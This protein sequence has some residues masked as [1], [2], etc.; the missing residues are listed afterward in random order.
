MAK[1]VQH[2]ITHLRKIQLTGYKSIKRLEVEFLPGLN[3]LIGKNNAGKTNFLEGLNSAL[4]IY[5]QRNVPFVSAEI[6]M[7]S[8]NEEIFKW[9]VDQTRSEKEIDNTGGSSINQLPKEKV[10]YN[11]DVVFDT[12][13]D[14]DTRVSRQTLREPLNVLSESFSTTRP[15]WNYIRFN[16]PDTFSLLSLKEPANFELIGSSN[17]TWVIGHSYPNRENPLEYFSR[18][19]VAPLLLSLVSESPSTIKKSVMSALQVAYKDKIARFSS[20]EDIRLHKN[21]NVHQ[22]DRNF[23][24][25]NFLIEFKVDGTWMPWSNLSDGT[26]RIFYL[27]YEVARIEHGTVLIDEPELGLYPDQFHQ[28]MQFLREEAE[29][30][31]IIVSTHAPQ[32]LDVIGPDELNRIFVA[33]YTKE[34]GTQI[35][36]LSTEQQDKAR[37][38]M[39][40]ELFLRDYW[41]HSGLEV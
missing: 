9:M 28:V 4:A 38:Y 12:E 24:I 11:G 35:Q 13:S 41:I 33:S 10:Y 40:E 3:I 29:Q 36:P 16:I 39:N 31:Q 7:I 26:K 25:S 15:I 22:S 1:E 18:Q 37:R 23:A 14:S 20:V 5:S 2:H 21:F 27:L 6:E 19:S 17:G 8:S 34:Q 32:A 30:K